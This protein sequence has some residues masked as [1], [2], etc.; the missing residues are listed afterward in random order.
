MEE[1]CTPY[2]R[3]IWYNRGIHSLQILAQT[4]NSAPLLASNTKSDS[5]MLAIMKETK[6]F[7]VLGASF[8]KVTGVLSKEGYLH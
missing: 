5:R 4:A 8:S 1:T 3:G 6:S 7:A 2:N